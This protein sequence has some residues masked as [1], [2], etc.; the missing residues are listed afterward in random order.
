MAKILISGLLKQYIPTSPAV[1]S[2]SN[3]YFSFASS[4]NGVTALTQYNRTISLSTDTESTRTSMSTAARISQGASSFSSTNIYHIKGYAAGLSTT[5]NKVTA[6]T[7]TQSSPT[8]AFTVERRGP[9]IPCPIYLGR[10]YYFGG[11]RDTDAT[12]RQDT[13]YIT[14]STDT[15]TN[16]ANVT[17]A[18][19][20]GS[21]LFNNSTAWLMG[22]YDSA[23]A[24]TTTIYKW[25]FSTSSISTLAAIDATQAQAYGLNSLSFGYRA[26]G[27]PS[28][29]N[30]NKKLT[31]A[32]DTVAAG[33]NSP[34]AI[35]IYQ[36]TQYVTSLI[37]YCWTGL[38]TVNNNRVLHKLTFA[39]E[40]WANANYTTGDVN[41]GYAQGTGGF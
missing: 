37:G 17:A 39:T 32:T 27:T 33:A 4:D 7:D 22:G 30:N 24:T 2:F 3:G 6:L 1:T 13:T 26:M 34:E 12:Y 11:Y 25:I 40:T 18:R 35:R 19:H 21:S 41:S 20:V 16:D 8:I 9:M 38:R 28:S 14:S 23:G 10:I 5:V 29:Y 31:Y 15:T 36:G